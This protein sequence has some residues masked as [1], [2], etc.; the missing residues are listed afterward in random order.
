[1]GSC[2]SLIAEIKPA[3]DSI[4]ISRKNLANL[5]TPPLPL[6]RQETHSW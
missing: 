2:P 6:C 5:L 4:H 1:M 3:H